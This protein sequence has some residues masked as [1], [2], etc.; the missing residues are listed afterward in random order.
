MMELERAQTSE[1]VDIVHGLHGA[2]FSNSTNID[3]LK[4]RK[5]SEKNP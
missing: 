5:I 2:C 4:F 1:C 3:I